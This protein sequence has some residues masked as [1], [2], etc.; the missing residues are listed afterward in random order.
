MKRWRFETSG[1]IYRVTLV[2]KAGNWHYWRNEDSGF[3][4]KEN[5][6]QGAHT[7][8]Q[9]LRAL[10]SRLC[11]IYFHGG[12]DVT[13]N[14]FEV[15]LVRATKAFRRAKAIVA[16][17]Q[18]TTTNFCPHCG[19]ENTALTEN[20]LLS[21]LRHVQNN[22]KLQEVRLAK[23]RESQQR[24]HDNDSIDR[25]ERRTRNV[26]SHEKSVAKWQGWAEALTAVIH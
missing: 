7:A 22:L 6:M 19:K 12:R 26:R 23:S 1:N 2:K 16:V 15:G 3:E 9:A 10:C 24:H 17:E 21:L 8:E 4:F 20:P 13:P 11:L 5:G 25:Q 18:E 14:R